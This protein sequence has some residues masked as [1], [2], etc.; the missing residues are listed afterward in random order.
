MGISLSQTISCVCK[1]PANPSPYSDSQAL[2]TALTQIPK[3]HQYIIMISPVQSLIGKLFFL[4]RQSIASIASS[5]QGGPSS[6]LM[7]VIDH[8]TGKDYT[9]PIAHNAVQAIHFQ[10]ICAEDSPTTP[11]KNEVKNGL[12]VLD[13][14]FHNTAVMESEV[15]YV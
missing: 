4:C 5:F 1:P 10:Q 8:R 11:R 14:G 13:P 15:T 12:R 3:T 2:C 9:I 7:T 6:G